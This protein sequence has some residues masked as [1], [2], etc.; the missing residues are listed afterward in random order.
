MII[1][2]LCILCLLLCT[3]FTV[4][5]VGVR[6]MRGQ[7]SPPALLEPNIA[8]I[9]LGFVWAY[10]A[11]IGKD[12]LL[13]DA[14]PDPLGQGI[15]HML[16]LLGHTG[17]D[18]RYIFLSHAHMD[19]TAAVGSFPHAQVFLGVGDIPLASGMQLPESW[20]GRLFTFIA[21][22]APVEVPHPLLHADEVIAV[23]ERKTVRAI[24]LKGH[25]PGSFAYLYDD[26][27][28]VG[29][30]FGYDGKNLINTPKFFDPH[31]S[32]NR[33]SIQALHQRLLQVP[34]QRICT[35][36]GGCTRPGEAHFFGESC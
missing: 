10:A 19:H 34:L 2:A 8:Q 26:M 20:L 12:V 18:V 7:A 13:F 3:L 11:S 1:R 9:K 36:H 23:G 16:T 32:Q 27:L 30:A 4:G 28:F 29:D 14:G 17:K 35:G 21:Q 22:P 25:T 33:T 6:S 15:S 5:V 24:A 31:P